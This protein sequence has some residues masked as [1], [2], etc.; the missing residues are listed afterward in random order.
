MKVKD[1]TYPAFPSIPRLSRE[2]VV[3]EKIDGTNGLIEVAKLEQPP[4]ALDRDSGR[5][6][7]TDTGFYMVCAGSRNRWLTL[8]QDN[9]GFC[10]WVLDHA[11]ELV[12]LGE[13][14]H[15][16]EWWGKG[17]QRGYGLTE[18]RFSLFNVSRWSDCVVRP[19]CCSVVPILRT[20]IMDTVTV[21]LVL[22][23]LAQ[24]GSYAAPGFMNPEGVVVY[25]RAANV[26]FKKTLGND[27]H[28]GRTSVS[29]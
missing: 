10:R 4:A 5:L 15:H 2:M 24:C 7:E 9:Y 28:K 29:Q 26:L 6:V 21:E 14:I 1:A 23:N 25:H 16:G 13:G 12:A 8:Q 11:E 20:G 19:A 27:G 18:K 22:S 17:I 3:T